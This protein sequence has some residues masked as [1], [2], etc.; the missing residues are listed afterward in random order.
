MIM[1][2]MMM[3]IIIII[4]ILMII[5]FLLQMHKKNV[6]CAKIFLTTPLGVASYEITEQLPFHA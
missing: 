3:I 4:I 5:Q 6:F 2:M 1:I